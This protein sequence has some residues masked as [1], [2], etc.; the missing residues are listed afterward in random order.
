VAGQFMEQK[1]PCCRKSRSCSHC[2]QSYIGQVKSSTSV[3]S[4]LPFQS[5][6][7]R[8]ATECGL[9]FRGGNWELL[10]E[11]IRVEHASQVGAMAELIR[12]SQGHRATD[13]ETP[14]RAHF[15]DAPLHMNCLLPQRLNLRQALFK[16]QPGMAGSFALAHQAS[17]ASQSHS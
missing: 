12:Q 14:G 7:V 15:L 6:G 8:S 5:Q 17:P 13:L 11:F 16:R 4:A 10:E 9:T 1:A 2:G 3:S